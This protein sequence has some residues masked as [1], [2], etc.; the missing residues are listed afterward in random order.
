MRRAYGIDTLTSAGDNGAGQTIVI[1]DSY[2]S[3]NIQS[4]LKQFDTAYGVPPPPS[5]TVDAPLGTVPFKSSDLTMIIWA[6][7]TTLDIEWAHAMAPGAGLVL[8]TSPVAQTRGVKGMP[9]FLQLEQYALDHHLGNVLSQSWGAPESTLLTPAGRSIISRFDSFFQQAASAGVTVL[10]ASGD[11]GSAQGG[12]PNP[13][14]QFP[15]SSPW[16]TTVGGTSLQATVTGHYQSEVTWNSSVG[17]SG[18]GVSQIESEPAYEQCLPA[19]DQTLLHGFRGLPDVAMNA[20]WNTSVPIFLSLPGAT[21]S[22]WLVGGTS[23]GSP[24]WAGIVADLNQRA[25]APLGFLNPL[26]YRLGC[27]GGL[28]GLMHDITVGTN[29]WGGVP[30]YVATPG[31]DPVTGWGT[32]GSPLGLLRRRG[33]RFRGRNVRRFDGVG[34]RDCCGKKLQGNLVRSHAFCRRKVSNDYPVAVNDHPRT[35]AVREDRLLPHVDAWLCDLFSADRI[36]ATAAQ[37]VEEDPKGT[38]KIQR[39]LGP[40]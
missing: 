13:T 36:E 19:G 18:G 24:V 10:A 9:Q 39:S 15:A 12:G 34:D 37:I 40:G 4:D 31:W 22:Y 2:G 28:A 17:A 25:G 35:L 30:G 23:E 33:L 11:H 29:A 1:V 38:G 6:E 16:V 20:D 27:S 26:L 3:P 32:P 14:V 7:E 21:G 5:F 8:L